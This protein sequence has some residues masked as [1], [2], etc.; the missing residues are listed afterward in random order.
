MKNKILY[1]FTGRLRCGTY[2]KDIDADEIIIK[3]FNNLDD[4]ASINKYISELILQDQ[5]FIRANLDFNEHDIKQHIKWLYNR[6]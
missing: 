3:F 2:R 6:Y 1:E 5:T 4:E